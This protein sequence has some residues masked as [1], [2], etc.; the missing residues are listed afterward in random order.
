[1]LN[2]FFRVEAIV[3]VEFCHALE[4]PRAMQSVRRGDLLGA[5]NVLLG[6]ESLTRI[7]AV[8][9]GVDA[10]IRRVVIFPPQ[11]IVNLNFTFTFL[12]LGLIQ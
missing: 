1:M 5:L 4:R 7:V 8:L 11:K 6:D 3:V 12:A 2:R 10:G 9:A